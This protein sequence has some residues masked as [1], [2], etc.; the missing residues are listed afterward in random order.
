MTAEDFKPENSGLYVLLVRSY[1]SSDDEYIAWLS[2]GLRRIPR[3]YWAEAIQDI[4]GDPTIATLVIQ[5]GT[6][7]VRLLDVNNLVDGLVDF[8]ESIMTGEEFVTE[9]IRAAKESWDGLVRVL[10]PTAYAVLKGRLLDNLIRVNSSVTTA[11]L[12]ILGK[13]YLRKRRWQ[14]ITRPSNFLMNSLLVTTSLDLGMLP[15][16]SRATESSTGPTDLNRR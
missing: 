7:G 8:S 1:G 6:G 13:R 10:D 4:S 16:F 12:E 5:L 14:R 15:A 11:F 2:E 9:D 3:T